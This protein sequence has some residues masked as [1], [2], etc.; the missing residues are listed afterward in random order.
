MAYVIF[1]LDGTVI[2][3]KHRYR[4]L[5]NG[6]ID[7]DYWFAM[8][9]PENI[10]KDSLLPLASTMKRLFERHMIVVCTARTMCDDDFQYLADNELYYH[11]ILYRAVDDLRSDAAMKVSLLN[12]YFR[13]EG[14]ARP[15]HANT[16]MYDDNERVIQ[17]MIAN[18]IHCFDANV[19]NARMVT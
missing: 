14:Y 16:I 6:S 3:S 8:R 12:E 11:A 18:H 10:A 17:A 4:N 5:P 19:I 1:D 13:S 2:C 7:L 15:R 9:T